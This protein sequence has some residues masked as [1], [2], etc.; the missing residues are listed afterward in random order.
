MY[1]G[2]NRAFSLDEIRTLAPSVFATVP[3]GDVSDKYTFIPTI[4]VVEL[5]NHEGFKVTQ[6]MEMRSRKEEYAGKAKHLLRFTHQTN[7]EKSQAERNDLILVNS[8]NRTSGFNFMAGCYRFACANGLIVGE[9]L[10]SVKT[11]HVGASTDDYINAAFEV[12]DRAPV[13]SASIDEMKALPLLPQEQEI[14]AESALELMDNKIKPEVRQMIR[15][16]RSADTGQ[17]LWTVFNVVQ[18]NMTRGGQWAGYSEKGRRQRTRKI[19][20][21]DKTVSVN[22]AL[23]TLAE[24]MKE[25]KA[26]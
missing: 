8:H 15:P 22:R 3:A 19:N 25:L 23:W 26:A 13:I 11:R 10:C 7:L 4:E 18:E 24:R 9:E 1:T 16:R 5:L 2:Q 6:A 14:F 20:S 12:V 17:D 21:V